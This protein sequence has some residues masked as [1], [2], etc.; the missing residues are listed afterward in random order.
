MAGPA[1]APG[2]V[3]QTTGGGTVQGSSQGSVY[4]PAATPIPMTGGQ[5]LPMPGIPTTPAPSTK[6]T[7]TPTVL[8]N[9][10]IIE[11]T[12]PQLN[13]RAASLTTDEPTQLASNPPPQAND[14]TSAPTS[15]PSTDPSSSSDYNTLYNYELGQLPDVTQD[16][17]YQSDVALINSL[18]DQGDATTSSYVNSIQ[19]NYVNLTSTLQAQQAA[20][21]AKISNA[22]L[23]GGSSRYA[24][25][26]SGGILNLQTRSDMSALANLQDEENQ[27]IA[28]VKQAQ[29][30]QD[31]NLMSKKMD[32]LDTLT[33]SKQNLAQTLATNLQKQNQT[34]QAALVQ[35]QQDNAIADLVQSGTTDPNDILTALTQ[36]G[37]TNATAADVATTLEGIQKATGSNNLTGDVK[38]F[39]ILKATPGGLPASILALPADQQMAAYISMVNLAKKGK[40]SSGTTTT[41]PVSTGLGGSTTPI[42][43]GA[44]GV[45]TDG[46]VNSVVVGTDGNPDPTEQQSFLSSL[47]GG[48]NSGL[49]TL[50]QGLADY[51][52]NP[53]AIPTRQ[54]AG[55]AGYTE[56][57]LLTLAKQYDPTYDSKQY[58]T[59]AAMQ[60]NVTSGTYSQTINAANTLVQ[61]LAELQQTYKALGNGGILPGIFNA[62]KN[63]FQQ[64]GGSGTQGAF[65]QAANAVATEAAKV[66]KGGAPT[67]SEIA[68]NAKLFSDN[69]SPGQFKAALSTMIGLMTG[70]LG[71]LASQYKQTMGKTAGFSILT[72]QSVS[73]LKSLGI[74]PSTVDPTYNSDSDV[75][76]SSPDEL[77]NYAASGASTSAY[78]PNSWNNAP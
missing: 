34:A 41:N 7:T 19:Q 23:L 30:S 44:P 56:P 52:I 72:P 6:T 35:N 8:S 40:V 36:Q 15:P 9:A 46:T 27:K 24:P 18:Q 37:F 11:N 4:T 64:I 73:T 20:N 67:E 55:A 42:T 12:I 48:S 71:T 65:N 50:V 70:R 77:L 76:G 16:P 28:E 53:T 5:S 38:N 43:P 49:A 60:K 26:S 51:S 74:D 3:E 17:T 63:T 14:S 13:Q 21:A 58:A 47:P 31:Y 29:N 2:P 66:Y 22:L 32:E 69:M 45:Q 75:G 10:N 57:Q 33:E 78:D 54:Y 25:V 62:G 61:H 68:E 59:R 39:Q 1:L